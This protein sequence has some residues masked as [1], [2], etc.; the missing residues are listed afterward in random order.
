MSERDRI[1][2]EVELDN[3]IKNPQKN[4]E[5]MNINDTNFN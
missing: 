3:K 1:I 2:A 4:L 5:K